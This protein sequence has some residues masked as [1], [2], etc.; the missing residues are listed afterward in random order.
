MNGSPSACTLFDDFTGARGNSAIIAVGSGWRRSDK[1]IDTFSSFG[2]LV[3]GYSHMFIFVFTKSI[4][5]QEL[6]HLVLK[7]A[8]S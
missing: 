6:C 7:R 2:I 8:M 5:E 1:S 4:I 3:N